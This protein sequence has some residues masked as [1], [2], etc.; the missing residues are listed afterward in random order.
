M[1]RSLFYCLFCLFLLS[2]CDDN[3]LY[4]YN[5]DLTNNSWGVDDTLG[6]RYDI[7]DT[8]RSYNLFINLR[9]TPRY[10]YSNL[11]LFLKITAPNGKY[12][13]DTV[14]CVLADKKGKWLGNTAAGIIE[15]KIAYK[16][17]IHFP[18]EGP[19]TV[20]Y[21]QAMRENELSG[22]ASVGFRIEYNE[23]ATN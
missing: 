9:N 3:R 7:Q 23:I 1:R 15:N 11:Y 10:Y 4:E 17:N 8:A 18:L 5:H 16:K 21:I 14:E 6:F 22:I 20:T 12:S 19:Y 13:I 2:S